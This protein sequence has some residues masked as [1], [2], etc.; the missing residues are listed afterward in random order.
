[1]YSSGFLL[2]EEVKEKQGFLLVAVADKWHQQ[3][4][5]HKFFPHFKSLLQNQMVKTFDIFLCIALPK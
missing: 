1:M 2:T 3:L 4:K 5:D